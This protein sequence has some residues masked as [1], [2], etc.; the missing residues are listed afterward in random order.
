MTKEDVWHLVFGAAALATGGG[1][2]CPTYEQFSAQADAFFQEGYKPTLMDPMDL[3]DD[4]LVFCNIGV[5]GGIIFKYATLYGRYQPRE[6]WLKQ[7]ESTTTL[8]SWSKLPEDRRGEEHIKRLTELV[9]RKPVAYIS[10]E[11]G[12]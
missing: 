9:G 5:G 6:G 1:G 8:N 12:H 2:S 11:C 3:M 7:L 10:F 4:D